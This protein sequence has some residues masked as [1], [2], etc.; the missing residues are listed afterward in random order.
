MSNP[1]VPD[2]AA[3]RGF[4]IRFLDGVEKIGNKLPDPAMLFLLLLGVV[5][6]LSWLLSM[7]SFET[8]NPR[9]DAPVVV[10][11]LMAGTALTEFIANMVIV[12]TSFPPL[13]V[14]L[15]AMMGLA[16][17]E[18]IGRASCRERV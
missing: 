5:M 9:T 14:V 13:G 17:A 12:F 6:V 18:Q 4:M 3:P 11:N 15:V 16:V 8:I 7:V 1:A 2:P 10:T